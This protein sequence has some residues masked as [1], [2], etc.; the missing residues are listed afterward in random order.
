M[1][2]PSWAFNKII[3]FLQFQKDRSVRGEITPATVRN[4]V[5]ALKLFC[6][7]SDIHIPW[8]KITRG[9]PRARDAG[10]NQSTYS[11]IISQQ[12]FLNFI[13]FI[14]LTKRLDTD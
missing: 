2:D 13:T 14:F 7:M 6:E 10:E 8:N 3:I 4:F 11:K 1:I 12:F 5:K 9:L